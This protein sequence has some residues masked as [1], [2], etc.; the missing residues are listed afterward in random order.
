MAIFKGTVTVKDRPFDRAVKVVVTVPDG[1][2]MPNLQEL[3]QRAWRTVGR[4]MTIDGIT[5]RVQ[6]FKR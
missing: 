5:V 1:T 3:A 2:P 4:T 6:P